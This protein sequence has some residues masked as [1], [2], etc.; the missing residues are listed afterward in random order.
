[1]SNEE[2]LAWEA[3]AGKPAA[4]AAFAAAL[5]SFAAGIYVQAAI[6]SPDADEYLRDAERHPGEFIVS[7]ILLA[8]ASLLLLPVLA[9][10]ARATRHRRPQFSRI[11]L[12]LAIAGT[13]VTAVTTVWRNVEIT[14][15]AKDFFPFVPSDF[16]DISDADDYLDAVDPEHAAAKEIREAFPL[17]VQAFGLLALA[18]SV[19]TINLN[20]MR[21]GLLSRFMG[22]LGI[23]A[24]VLLIIPIP[25]PLVELF[26]LGA[27]GLLFLGRWPGA[28]RGPAWETGE[29]IPWPS[30]AGQQALRAGDAPPEE[31]EPEPHEEPEPEP[32]APR[33]ASRKRRKKKRG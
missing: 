26:W 19:V 22:I 21:A 15:L 1:V 17:G 3:R 18:F 25:I 16:A 13:V 9:Y 27:L 29:P 24:G 23:F 32:A 30:A 7:G 2:Q 28:G 8:I 14:N 31:D 6:G 4:I 20:A 11:A 5:T 12:Y 10:L 33:P